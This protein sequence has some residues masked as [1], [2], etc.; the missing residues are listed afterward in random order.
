MDERLIEYMR[1]LPERAVHAYMLQ[2][3]LKWPLRKIAKEMKITSQTVGRYTY[4][5]RE[6]LYR[7]AVDNGIEPSQIYRDD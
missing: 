6:A 4:D 3:M 7:Y 5:I 2:R 1:S